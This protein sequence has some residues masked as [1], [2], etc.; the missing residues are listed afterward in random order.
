MDVI[1]THENADFDAVASLLAAA[2][3]YPTAAP[4][5]PRR[6][7]R[8]VQEF[9]TLYGE[10]LPFHSLDEAVPEAIERVI[11]VDCQAIPSLKGLKPTATIHFIDH[12]P[13][14]K[15][16]PAQAT[17]EGRE[18]GATTTL[19]VQ[20]LMK[21]PQSLSPIEAALLMLGI[22]EDTGSLSYKGTRVEDFQAATWLFERGASLDLIQEYLHHALSAGQQALYQ[23]LI[24]AARAVEVAGY[25][26]VIASA[27]AGGHVEEVSTLAHHLRDL[28]ACDALFVLAQMD[29][30]VQVVARSTHDAIDVGAIMAGLGGGGHARAAAAF[31]RDVALEEAEARLRAL[32]RSHI[33]PLLTAGQIMSR[34][35]RTLAPEMPIREAEA[36]F[37]RYGHEGFPVVNGQ[38][39][40]LGIL[41]R[42]EVDRAMHHQLGD[43]PI[44]SYM[45]KGA[46]A[47]DRGEAV[48]QVRKTMIERGL[49]QVPVVQDGRLV[50]IVTRTDLIK[51]WGQ[52]PA[53]AQALRQAQEVVARF[54]AALPE[55][56]L[57]LIRAAGG[58][59]LKKNYLLY[60]VGGFVRDLLLSMPN[61]DIDLVV[62]GDA[63]KL[64]RAM[65]ARF[66]G[67]VHAH[68]RFGTA[69]WMLDQR[70]V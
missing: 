40:L 64:A 9:L 69:K 23:K 28:F 36:L 49:G 21:L 27:R 22:Y 65:A 34:S 44:A 8:N 7:N 18:V 55:D 68:A 56:L 42:R 60:V 52:P 3:L 63:I 59:A 1:V 10:A 29:G 70:P 17:H 26:V 45:H 41:T 57:I 32:C 13:F 30:H 48:E 58:V 38:D 31:L 14:D 35:V 67:H 66:G 2:R 37:K 61:S 43:M 20:Q 33:H 5:L 4:L 39:E 50:G 51:M 16:L 47:V 53:S 54:E 6:V 24:Q 62:E 19:L 11:A 12:H 25:S 46:I 15:T